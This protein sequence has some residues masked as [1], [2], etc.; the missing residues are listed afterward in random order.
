MFASVTLQMELD[1]ILA[2]ESPLAVLL[3]GAAATENLSALQLLNDL[4]FLV[5]TEKSQ[6]FE[7]SVYTK[8]QIK[9]D[10]SYLPVELLYKG[11]E[12]NWLFLRNI[13]K[14]Y[15][16]IYQKPPWVEEILTKVQKWLQEPLR[17]TDEEIRYLRFTLTQSWEDL[18]NRQEDLLNAIYL[19]HTLLNSIL[20]AYFQLHQ[21][22]APKNKKILAAIKKIDPSLFELCQSFLLEGEQNLKLEKLHEILN[23]VLTPFGGKLTTWAKGKF[24]LR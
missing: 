24:P 15:Q 12:E 23:Y 2:L 6:Y 10:I 21:L 3:I 19:A 13:F 5:I 1:Q 4:D 14:H 7:R 18:V 11:M 16:V 9:Y 20:Q 17:I 22:D 8:N